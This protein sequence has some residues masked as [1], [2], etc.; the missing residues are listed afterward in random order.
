MKLSMPPLPAGLCPAHT[1]E[2]ENAFTARTLWL[3][4]RPLNR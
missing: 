3:R 4:F 1:L 2:V